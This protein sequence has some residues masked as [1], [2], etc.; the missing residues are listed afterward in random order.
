[1]SRIHSLSGHQ[2][3]KQTSK[4]FFGNNYSG[5]HHDLP[6]C[7]CHLEN[8]TNRSIGTV[9]EIATTRTLLKFYRSFIP[10]HFSASIIETMC[11]TS[12]AHL[13]F[14]LG[15]ITSHFRANHPLKACP[16]CM[17]SD[18]LQYGWAYW[19]M[20]HQYPGV[21]SCPTHNS[22][23]FES[24]V[25]STGV[26]RF[27][28]HLPKIEE[29]RQWP[30]NILE[31]TEG[32]SLALQ[33]LSKT[34]VDLVNLGQDIPYDTNTFWLSYRKEL[35]GRGWLKGQ[36]LQFS[37]MV[38][39]FLK[40]SKNLRILPEFSTLPT[41]NQEATSQLGRI[42]RKPRSGIHPL[43]HIILI[44]WLFGGTSNFLETYNNYDKCQPTLKTTIN[45]TTDNHPDDPLKNNVIESLRNNEMS[46]R[47][48]SNEFE[49]DINIVMA[50]AAEA[51]LPI[52]RRPKKL[53]DNIREEAIKNLRSGI[54]KAQLALQ[55]DISIPTINRLLRTVT[56]LQHQWR[57]ARFKSTLHKTRTSW[58]ELVDN[59]P[60]LGTKFLRNLEPATY[61]WLYRNDR[62]WLRQHSPHA[63][64]PPKMTDKRNM[65]DK[66]DLVLS[67]EVKRTALE[68]SQKA[69][70]RLIHLWQLYQQIPEL[71]A[72]LEVLDKLPLTKHAIEKVLANPK[73]A[74]NLNM[75]LF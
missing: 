31:C 25:K 47:A 3:S 73:S 28:W 24:L 75:E 42:L 70:R 40:Y 49:V 6:N 7:L 27:L 65:W 66:R 23:L 22:S 71:K 58:K 36:R 33:S 21:W 68:L 4:H 55:F 56:G 69:P 59:Y 14:Q 52:T 8:I 11:S 15:L 37:E 2:N 13:K 46:I 48:V 12:V 29:L 45:I 39:E 1:I 54:D 67:T 62:D 72:K 10:S 20:E 41:T 34:T 16:E 57:T 19:H 17:S 9:Y 18:R 30:N 50:W 32:T 44:D 64:N 53:K 35:S 74:S 61:A 26:G 51:G 60:K 63:D 5:T 38:D 43:R